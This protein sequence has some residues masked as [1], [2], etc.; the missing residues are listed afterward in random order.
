MQ[1]EWF[2]KGDGSCL[3][4]PEQG[5]PMPGFARDGGEEPEIAGI[6]MISPDGM[7]FRIGYALGNEFSDH[8][9]ERENYLW[10]AHSKLRACSVGPELLVGELPR[11]CARHLAHPARQRGAVG[12]AVRLGRGEHVARASPISSGTISNT[13]CSAGRATCMCISSAPRR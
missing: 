11:G 7:P 1:P 13:A 8:V 3:V 2:Y 9:T 4:A 6:Y 10:L 5:L 12:E